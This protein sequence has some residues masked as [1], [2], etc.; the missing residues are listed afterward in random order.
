MSG[1]EITNY[2]SNYGS[3]GQSAD[4]KE[5]HLRKQMDEVISTRTHT[6]VR[7]HTHTHIHIHTHLTFEL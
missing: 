1:L 7:T 2:R 5:A 6:H 4:E 3:C